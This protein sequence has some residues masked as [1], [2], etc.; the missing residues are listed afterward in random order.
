MGWIKGNS[1]GATQG[2]LGFAL[3]SVIFRD[4]KGAAISCL[5]SFIGVAV[6]FEAQLLATI[7][8][9]ETTKSKNW[10]SFWLECL[11]W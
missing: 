8:A 9:I 4:D 11:C 7:L 5:T 2:N 3:V 6:V 1:D 10:H